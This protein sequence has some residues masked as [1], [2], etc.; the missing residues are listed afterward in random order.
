M[1]NF[2]IGITIVLGVYALLKALYIKLRAGKIILKLD[3]GKGDIIA[4]I[5]MI[6]FCVIDIM[7]EYK[8]YLQYKE[9]FPVHK[10]QFLNS[11]V[12]TVIWI[13][14]FLGFIIYSGIRENGI[15]FGYSFYSWKRIIGWK[16][17]DENTIQLKIALFLKLRYTVKFHVSKYSI[18]TMIEILEKHVE[19]DINK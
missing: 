17:L 2:I 10:A 11:V 4:F 12:L 9:K 6:I 14:L 7:N 8:Y 18:W 13:I 15:C 16:R 19:K 5:V 3:E 1:Y